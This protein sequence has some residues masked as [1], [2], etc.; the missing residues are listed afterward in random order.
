MLVP[1]GVKQIGRAARPAD[2]RQII[3]QSGAGAHPAGER[4]MHRQ[5]ELGDM[6]F[7][8]LPFARI[9]RGIGA[10]ELDEARRLHGIGIAGDDHRS[11]FEHDRRQV[12][13][14][15]IRGGADV[16]A[17]FGDD[18]RAMAGALDQCLAADARG[19]EH[20]IG[21]MPGYPGPA[22]FDGQRAGLAQDLPA[23]AD[24]VVLQCVRQSSEIGDLAGAFEA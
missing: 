16:I 14:P 20:E 22:V 19:D 13:G 18:R 24:H 6:A 2:R 8:P 11:V 5:A 15:L 21:I 9:G 4:R 1:E 12:G 10:R 7:E 23:A 3:G 17:A